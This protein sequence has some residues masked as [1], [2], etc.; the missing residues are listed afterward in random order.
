MKKIKEKKTEEKVRLV[1]VQM[2]EGELYYKCLEPFCGVIGNWGQMILTGAC[3]NRK[4][5]HGK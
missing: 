3:H 4:Q 5:K 1:A 2:R